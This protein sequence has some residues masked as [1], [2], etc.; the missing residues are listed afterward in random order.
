MVLGISWGN[1]LYRIVKYIS[2]NNRKNIP[3]TVV[4][5]MGAANIKTPEKDAMDLA[6]ELASA[7][8]V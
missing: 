2:T 8:C 7:R 4:P 1:T 6:K 3:V 5:I